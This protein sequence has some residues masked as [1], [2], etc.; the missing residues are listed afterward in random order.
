VRVTYQLRQELAQKFIEA[1]GLLDDRR[2]RQHIK[3]KLA[4]HIE[5]G[6]RLLSEIDTLSAE[7]AKAKVSGWVN[8]LC[9]FVQSA[10]GEA[11]KAQLINHA[12]LIGMGGGPNHLERVFL[13][14][15]LTRLGELMQR[16]DGVEIRIGFD[17]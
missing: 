10:L 17:P 15:C 13:N 9:D 14:F 5:E 2:R 16:A 1:Q 8:D 12:G 6:R 7:L 3:T 11:E 4:G